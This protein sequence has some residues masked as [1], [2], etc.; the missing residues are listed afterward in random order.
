MTSLN[1]QSMLVNPSLD[2]TSSTPQPDLL[3]AVTFPC[4]TLTKPSKIYSSTAS[5]DINGPSYRLPLS[6]LG[7]VYPPD[8]EKCSSRCDVLDFST[9]EASLVSSSQTTTSDGEGRRRTSSESERLK[10]Q[11]T[12]ATR[13]EYLKP[14]LASAY[15]AYFLCGWGDGGMFSYLIINNEALTQHSA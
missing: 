3:P 14:R 6:P 13:P 7:P 5:H 10:Q 8:L 15:F 2:N 11:T 12:D 1:Q 4:V 9:K